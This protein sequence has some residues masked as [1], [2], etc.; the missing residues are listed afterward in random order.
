MKLTTDRHEASRGLF[1]TA[2]L[3]V[4]TCNRRLSDVHLADALN[5]SSSVTDVSATVRPIGVNICV[6]VEL[7][8][9]KIFSPFG[10]DIFG[11]NQM[12]GQ[13]RDSGGPFLAVDGWAVTFDT[14]E[15]GLGGATARPGSSSL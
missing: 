8:P 13:R 10:G 11:G 14:A 9:I 2:E 7:S 1:A 3:L 15:S 4:T 6:M 12:R 5:C